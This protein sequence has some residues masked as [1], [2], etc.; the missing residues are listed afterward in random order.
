MSSERGWMSRI[1][2][3]WSETELCF[4]IENSEDI[5]VTSTNVWHAQYREDRWIT[6]RIITVLCRCTRY[7]ICQKTEKTIGGRKP[8]IF[9]GLIIWQGYWNLLTAI[10]GKSQNAGFWSGYLNNWCKLSWTKEKY[11]CEWSKQS[12]LDEFCWICQTFDH[13]P[14]QL[15]L[16]R[17]NSWEIRNKS[18]ELSWKNS[19]SFRSVWMRIK[20]PRSI[21]GDLFETEIERIRTFSEGAR[22]KI[23]HSAI[24]PCKQ[25]CNGSLQNS[26]LR[27]AVTKRIGEI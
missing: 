5:W 2:I 17:V 24:S 21:D 9:R 20:P 15:G 6:R 3:L 18:D 25:L 4:T 22:H 7:D 1:T 12:I 26:Y 13:N 10:T 16:N 14:W 11:W 23:E 19:I 8:S 27:C